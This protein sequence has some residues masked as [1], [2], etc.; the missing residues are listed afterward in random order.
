[1]NLFTVNNFGS[2]NETKYSGF[3]YAYVVPFSCKYQAGSRITQ[4]DYHMSM[5]QAPM[6]FSRS[7]KG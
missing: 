3:L 4:A 2:R 6:P 5:S 7:L 1:M